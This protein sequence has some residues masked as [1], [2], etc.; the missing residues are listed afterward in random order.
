MKFRTLIAAFGIFLGLSAA[1]AQT[2]KFEHVILISVDGLHGSDVDQYIASHPKSTLAQLAGMGTVYT[3]AQSGLP[4]DSYP[5]LAALI[6]GGSPNSTGIWYDHTYNRSLLAPGSTKANPGKPGVDLAF[7][8]SVDMGF[9]DGKWGDASTKPLEFAG[10]AGLDAKALPVDPKTFLPVYPHNY[11]LVNTIFEVAQ[12]AGKLTAWSDKHPAYDLV[13]GPSGKGVVDLFTPEINS[14][15]PGKGEDDFTKD[16]ADTMTYDGL[17]VQAVVNE[18]KGF[19]HT[20]KVKAGVPAILGMNFQTLSVSQKLPKGGYKDAKA[21][22]SD[23]LAK[24]LDSVDAGL[25]LILATVKAEKL[26]KS[27]LFIISAKHAQSPID[28]STVKWVDD[29]NFVPVLAAKGITAFTASNDTT[30]YLWLADPKQ[31]K[32]AADVLMAVKTVYPVWD[33]KTKKN[34]F[35]KDETAGTWG[36]ID[37]ILYG[38]A[39]TAQ[40]KDPSGTGRF[41]DL[42]VMNAQGTVYGKPWK[43]IAE[44]GGFGED[45]THVGLIVAH[46]G[47]KAATVAT[48]VKTVQVAPTVLKA[49]GLDP[50]KLQAVVQEKTAVLP[51]LDF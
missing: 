20:G 38:D 28:V 19:D 11:L 25:G 40:F 50:A 49:L 42:I 13:N 17:K 46:V 47:G 32:A 23:Y 33:A 15:V 10:A 8:E 45:D 37:K 27:T 44:H 41:P 34:L 2:P 24:G 4:S 29:S 48:A 9:N 5:G 14:L 7:D 22:P 6:T 30:A 51:A 18:L 1:S 16:N 31:A 21:T 39:L 43:K 12:Q 3:K 26:D 35:E 36:A